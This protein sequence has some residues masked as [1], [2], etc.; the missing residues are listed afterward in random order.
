MSNAS[1]PA[2]KNIIFDLGGVVLDIDYNL[3]IKAFQKL[4]IPDA[5]KLYSKSSQIPLFDQLEKGNISEE[6]FYS[7]IR[8]LSGRDITDDEIRNAW[9]AML[10]GLPENNVRML[11]RLKQ[12]YHLFL[13]SNT[14]AIHE[15]GYVKMIEKQYGSFIFNG[16]FEKIYLSHQIHLRK[17]DP[18]IFRYVLRDS[19]LEITETCFIDDSPQ[20]VQGARETGLAAFHMKE[21]SLDDF[22]TNHAGSFPE[23]NKH[24]NHTA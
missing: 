6:E 17:P 3:S 15:T 20:H 2:F 4:G 9:N 23:L 18:E 16:L 12:S 14:N 19:N 21:K 5:E 11:R 13:L 10:I 24:G 22:F 7:G 8:K 1:H